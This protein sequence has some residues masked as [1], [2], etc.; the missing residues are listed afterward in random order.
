M[1]TQSLAYTS[2]PPQR[3][4]DGPSPAVVLFHGRGADETD[5][6]PI[7]EYLPETLHVFAVRAPL[8]LEDGYGWY[9]MAV[10]QGGLHNSQPKTDSLSETLTRVGRFLKYIT[11][12]YD[13]AASKIGL[14]GF[15]QGG[16]LAISLAIEMPQRTAWVVAMHAY[17]PDSH[18]GAQ[19]LVDARSVPMFLGAGE[20][21]LVVPEERTKRAHTRLQDGGIDVTYRSYSTGHS[22]HE[23]ELQDIGRWVSARL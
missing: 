18:R 14:L 10:G 8:S 9:Q 11:T 13:I 22:A 12:T 19:Q 4:S 17:L 6:L 5:L 23:Q 3:Q 2:R 15:S 20:V 16:T 1:S 7:V 21:D